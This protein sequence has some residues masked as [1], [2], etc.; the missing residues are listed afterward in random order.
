MNR[1]PVSLL[2]G[3]LGS[4]KTTILAGL[5]RRPELRRTAVVMNEFGE[6]G[7]DHQLIE[8]SDD[9]LI[10]LSTGCLCCISRG[11][12]SRTI[13]DLLSRRSAGEILFDRIVVETTGLADPIPIL[14]SFMVD[15]VLVDRVRLAR[16][17]ATVDA[18]VGEQ[19]LGRREEARRQAACADAIVVTKGDL[20]S[21]GSMEKLIH[22]LRRLNSGAE[23]EEAIFGKIDPE[24][25]LSSGGQERSQMD[26]KEHSHIHGHTSSITLRRVEPVHAAAVPLFFEA[27]AEVY[28]PRLLRLKGLVQILEAPE[29]PGVVH[30]VQNLFHPLS[31]LDAWPN[32]EMGTA[33]TLIGE[34]LSAEFSDSL[35]AM[36]DEEVKWASRLNGALN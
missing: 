16:V 6:V 10:A 27:L 20:A 35:L 7:L 19:T 33:I 36:L 31:W 18:V 14:Q 9:D 4:G 3:F 1:V 21:A 17:V 25:I 32:G 23:I 11:D 22:Q 5:L 8:F 2:T 13:G 29:R 15:P 28:G 24:F 12:L 26:V 34:G 30:G